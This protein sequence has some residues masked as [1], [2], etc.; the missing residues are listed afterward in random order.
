M[1]YRKIPDWTLAYFTKC[2]TGMK[3]PSKYSSS[4]W[5]MLKGCTDIWW[6]KNKDLTRGW[7]ECNCVKIKCDVLDNM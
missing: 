1:Q 7:V 3:L 5:N 6:S 4:V 2:E